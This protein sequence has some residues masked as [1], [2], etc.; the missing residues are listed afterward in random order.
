MFDDQL[1]ERIGL[2]CEVFTPE[3]VISGVLIAVT[4]DFAIV[5]TTSYPGYGG[6]EDVSARLANIGYVRFFA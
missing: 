4:E 3:Q 6:E 5:R 1:R 2:S